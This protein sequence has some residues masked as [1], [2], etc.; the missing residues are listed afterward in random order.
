MRFAYTHTLPGCGFRTGEVATPGWGCPLPSLSV[1]PASPTAD[2]E[3]TAGRRL[4]DIVTCVAQAHVLLTQCV[5]LD[6]RWRRQSSVV[7]TRMTS[8]WSRVWVGI[9]SGISRKSGTK[10]SRIPGTKSGQSILRCVHIHSKDFDVEGIKRLPSYM[11]SKS[12][13]PPKHLLFI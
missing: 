8:T 5:S 13:L 10:F 4:R 6:W 9:S 12:F 1:P 11:T 7:M 2:E 3:D